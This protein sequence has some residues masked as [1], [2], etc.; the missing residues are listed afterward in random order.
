MTASKAATPSA[1]PEIAMTE[2]TEM[3]ARFLLRK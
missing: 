2:I 1:T 3:L